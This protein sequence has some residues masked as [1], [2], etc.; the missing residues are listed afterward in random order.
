M[1]RRNIQGRLSNFQKSS[2]TKHRIK[3][4]SAIALDNK[5]WYAGYG[6]DLNQK[7]RFNRQVK[8]VEG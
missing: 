5:G 3:C 8:V 7:N 1:F 2:I 6:M 4:Y